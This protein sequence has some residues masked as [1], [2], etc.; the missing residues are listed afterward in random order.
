MEIKVKWKWLKYYQSSFLKI[1][2]DQFFLFQ[3]TKN[4]AKA[5]RESIRR[6][7][8]DQEPNKDIEQSAEGTDSKNLLI[9]FMNETVSSDEEANINQPEN[10]SEINYNASISLENREETSQAKDSVLESLST[11]SLT[12]NISRHK[13]HVIIPLSK[14]PVVSTVPNLT[15]TF[16]TRVAEISTNLNTSSSSLND[17]D[18]EDE[19]PISSRHHKWSFTAAA[20]KNRDKSCQGWNENSSSSEDEDDF[21]QFIENRKA[22]HSTQNLNDSNRTENHKDYCSS[23]FV[24]DNWQPYSFVSENQKSNDL[25]STPKT[26]NL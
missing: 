4:S 18:E 1:Q 23:D 22:V 14:T 25:F 20:M 10:K 13:G 8:A 26:G 19:E 7:L 3:T 12:N 5:S 6:K 11:S 16:K 17:D 2:L 24:Q 9:C 15:D 21:D